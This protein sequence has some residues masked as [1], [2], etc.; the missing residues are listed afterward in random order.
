MREQD[1]RVNQYSTLTR[2]S[3]DS[4]TTY[5]IVQKACLTGLW[6]LRN[7]YAPAPV[8]ATCGKSILVSGNQT[9]DFSRP[10]A[11]CPTSCGCTFQFIGV[12]KNPNNQRAGRTTGNFLPRVK[13][14]A[15]DLKQVAAGT[16]ISVC[17]KSVRPCHVLQVDLVVHGL[18]SFTV[19]CVCVSFRVTMS[20]D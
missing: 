11:E 7:H 10:A 2:M 19:S 9:S 5:A 3:V 6:I 14:S 1:T 8:L 15:S 12:V 13:L 4:V 16:L 17:H 18:N 20:S